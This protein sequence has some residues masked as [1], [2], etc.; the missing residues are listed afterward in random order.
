[1]KRILGGLAQ[2]ACNGIGGRLAIDVEIFGS[3]RPDLPRR[4]TVT[5]EH[6]LTVSQVAT[7]IGLNPDEIGLIVIDGVQSELDAAVPT[8]CRLCFFAPVSGG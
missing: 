4:Q 5:L 2:I 6:P 1:M 3:L 8:T 7:S